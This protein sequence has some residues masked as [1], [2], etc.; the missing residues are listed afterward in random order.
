M[1]NFYKKISFLIIFMGVYALASA[2]ELVTIN[3]KVTDE[4]GDVIPGVNVY[5]ENGNNKTTTDHQGNFSL[6][7]PKTTLTIK[8]SYVGYITASRNINQNKEKIT[9]NISLSP[10]KSDLQQVEITGRKE[11]TYKNT[12][13]FIGS[14]SEILLKDLPQSVSYASKELIADQGAV[15]VG[16]VVKN[17][18]GVNQFTFYDDITIRGFRINGGSNTQLINGMRTSTGFWKQPLANYLERVEVLK[19]P[20][21]ALYGNASPGGVIN[22]VTKKPLAETRKSLSLSMGSY[23]TFR[24]LGDVTGP[25]NKDSTLLYRLNFGYEDANSFRDMQFDKNLIIAPSLTFLP[26]KN[27]SLNFDLVYNDSKSRL[28][29]GQSVF[30]NGNLYSTPQ[31]TSLNTGND[32]LNEKTYNVSLSLNHR[33]SENL[34]FTAS[35]MK[36][37]YSEDLYEHRS[38]NTYALDATGKS[39]DNLIAMQIFNR[40]RKRYID[41]FSGFINY[42]LKTGKIEQTIVAGYDY[43]SEKLP[44]G[45]SQLTATNYRNAA[46]TGSISFVK[47]EYDKDPTNYIKKFLVVNNLLVPNVPSFNL[48][49]VMASQRMQDDSKN[50]FTQAAYDPTY[51]FLNAGYVQDNIKFGKLQALLGLRYEYY[52]DYSNYLK[53]TQATANSK[54]LLPRFGLVYSAITNI[55][56]YGTY[57]MGYTPQTA[58]AISNPNAGGPFDPL[59]SNMIE[60]GAKTSWLDERLT[61]SAAIYQIKQKNVLYNANVVGQPDLLRS[62]GEERSRGIEFDIIGRIIPQLSILASYSYNEA[63]IT[64]SPIASEIGRQKPNAPHHTANI[65]AKYSITSGILKGLGIGGGSNYVDSRILSIDA[66]QTIPS[67]TLFNAAFYYN[68]GKVQVQFNMNNITNKVHWVGGYDYLRLFPGTPSNYLFTLGYTFN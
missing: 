63:S 1:Y 26:S 16:E 28:D 40:I 56:L 51:Y 39:V 68:V 20:S 17:F 12:A 3:G 6:S 27:T 44:V 49:D 57:V 67:Y 53:P 5:A 42:K 21:S 64:D 30:G 59:K 32:H 35:Y 23:N 9:L 7:V 54:A 46:N 41:N 43:A 31:S 38:A 36:T 47:S 19:G 25:A 15:R 10:T 61:A 14:K 50:F 66:T 33:F 4:S 45:A 58:S 55:N 62:V 22:R 34:N 13:T 2:Q 60:F 48:N 11:K 37:G 18:S 52:T 24:A 29:R 65:W 8:F